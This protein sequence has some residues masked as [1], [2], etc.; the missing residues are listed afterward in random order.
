MSSF[1]DTEMIK[2]LRS[3][4]LAD[5]KRE[6]EKLQARLEEAEKVIEFYGDKHN[7]ESEYHGYVIDDQINPTDLEI[8]SNG[9]IGGKRAREYQQKYK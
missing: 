9:K 8:D 3:K 5:M 4:T 2:K 1:L 7:W 6:N